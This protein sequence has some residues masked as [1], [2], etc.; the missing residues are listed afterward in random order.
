M[1]PKQHRVPRAIFS[2]VIRRGNGAHS[3]HFSLKTLTVDDSKPARFSFVISKKV[4]KRAV[5]RNLM[6]RRL[7]AVIAELLP[8]LPAGIVGIFFAKPRSQALAFKD[9]EEEIR[10]LVKKLN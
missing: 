3:A 6:R 10:F 4:D 2:T 7:S 1:L 5:K 9:I 8:S